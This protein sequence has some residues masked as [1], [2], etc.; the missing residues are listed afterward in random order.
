[1]RKYPPGTGTSS[2][3]PCQY[4]QAPCQGFSQATAAGIHTCMDRTFSRVWRFLCFL[5]AL[6][7]FGGGWFVWG[8]FSSITV[9]TQ[10]EWALCHQA[11][12]TKGAAQ[13]QQACPSEMLHQA[14]LFFIA[15]IK[16]PGNQERR[17]TMLLQRLQKVIKIHMGISCYNQG[18]Q[19]CPFY[20]P[21]LSTSTLKK[22]F[23]DSEEGTKVCRNSEV[24]EQ[25]QPG[26][27]VHLHK[28]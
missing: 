8:F 19:A 24:V 22:M 4:K 11:A 9:K 5:F 28:F 3:I 2:Q 27:N 13:Q 21:L 7:W 25:E 12:P 1:M 17:A 18:C 16:K 26:K 6:V 10:E 15:C 23:Q 20:R 14:L